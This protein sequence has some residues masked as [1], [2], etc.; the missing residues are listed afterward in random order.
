MCT[1]VISV[2]EGAAD[3]VRVLAVRDEDPAR[4]WDPPGPWWPEHPGVV[5]VRDRRAGGAWLAADPSRRRLAVLLNRADVLP[6]GEPAPSRGAVALDAVTGVVPAPGARLGMH[7]FNLVDVDGSR[8]RVT[9]WDGD[10]VRQTVL[11]PGT[12]M[13]AH[14]DVDD[15]ATARIVRWRA[16]FADAVMDARGP[17]DWFRPWLDVLAETAAAGPLDDAAIV[18]DNRPHGYPT[19]SLL[20]CT[21]TISDGVELAWAPLEHPG[22]WNPLDLR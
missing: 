5:G 7:G 15:P 20:V 11:A 18:R 8:A 22:Q 3:P 2:P 6:A 12:H 19:Q 1:V 9:T 14:D 16:A 17:G 10:V 4:P 13:I 21:A